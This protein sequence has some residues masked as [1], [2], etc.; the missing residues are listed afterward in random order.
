MRYD[1][2][3]GIK[4]RTEARVFALWLGLLVLPVILRAQ[5]FNFP[6]NFIPLSTVNYVTAANSAGDHLVVGALAGALSSLSVLPQPASIN[7]MFCNSQVQLAPQ[8]FYPNVY[9]PAPAEQLGNF[10][11][12]A[13]LL[14]DPLNGQPFP[15]QNSSLP[16]PTELSTTSVVLSG[17]AQLPLL[18]VSSSQ[19]NVLIPYEAA[20]N[21]THQ[22][23]VQ[24]NNAIS[25]PVST[26]VFNAAPAILST[27]GNG[28]GQGHIYVVE[29]S[30][31]ETLADQNS[32]ATAGNTVVIYC[33]GLGAVNPA[34]TSGGAAPGVQ[35]AY[36][37]AAVTVTFGG[38]T[39]IPGFA[40]LTP[41]FAG[42]YQ[43]NVVVPTGVTPGNQVPVTLSASGKSSS[44]AIFMAI[45]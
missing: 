12:F 3:L 1:A 7:Q 43:V 29:P 44:G 45:K 4:N 9:V 8:Q 26:S 6:V 28:L 23:V 41:G 18:Y 19:I 30:G 16:L 24:R 14:V 31:A 38:Q 35:L 11:A 13:G 39:A 37:S 34:V 36:A 5:C 27:A 20:A 33:V 22:L 10:S 17:G 25:V 40:G 32:P 15:G 2:M 42:L 21:A